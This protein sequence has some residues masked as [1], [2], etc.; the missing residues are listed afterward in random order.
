[1]LVSKETLEVAEMDDVVVKEGTEDEA[2]V[3]DMIELEV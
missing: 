3:E 1:M 2:F